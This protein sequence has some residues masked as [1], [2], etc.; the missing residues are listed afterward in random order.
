MLAFA[1]E[2]DHRPC[3]WFRNGPSYGKSRWLY[4]PAVRSSGGDPSDA[5]QLSALLGASPLLSQKVFQSC[6]VE[7][8]VRKEP[9]Q[10][11]VLV[12][13]RL[14]PLGFG[15]VHAAEFRFPFIDAGIADAV[16]AAKLRDRRACLVLLQYPNNLLVLE[17]V[18]LHFLGLSMGQSLLQNGLVQR[19]KVIKL[20]ENLFCA[21]VR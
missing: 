5:R 20:S 18:A 11:R 7:H 13:Q 15:H 21:S 4:T 12:F 2:D 17:T 8:R 1:R 14:Q 3:A 10:L 9:L 19:G 16:L 6:I